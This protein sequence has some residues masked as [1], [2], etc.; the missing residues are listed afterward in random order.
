MVKTGQAAASL[1]F[2]RLAFQSTRHPRLPVEV[3]SRV[4][5]LERHG[6]AFFGLPERLDFY[7]LIVTTGGC[8]WHDVDFAPVE[9]RPG[10]MLLIRPG[11]V[12]RFRW[13]ETVAAELVVF[14]PESVK[15]STRDRFLPVGTESVC[16]QLPPRDSQQLRSDIEVLRVEQGAFDGSV[17]RADLL[18]ARLDI[19]LMQ[20]GISDALAQPVAARSPLY[21]AFCRLVEARFATS[22]HAQEYANSLRCSHRT[23]N[24][25]CE[26]ATGR[27][28]KELVDHRVALEANRLLIGTERPQ[29]QIATDLGFSETTNFG[30]FFHRMTGLT[31]GEYRR[32]SG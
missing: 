26:L 27:S 1:E 30:K 4:E 16:G 31:P 18:R 22:R 29:E 14:P 2:R 8:G 10:G 25:A 19:A 15:R 11:Q 13:E 5:L 3:I 21:L 32:T 17:Q 20:V 6:K 24:R 9:L 7:L 23:L 28:A 12:H